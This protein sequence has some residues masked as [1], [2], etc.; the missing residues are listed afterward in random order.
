M[1]KNPTANPTLPYSLKNVA[2]LSNNPRNARTHSKE[3]I[4]KIAK[5]IKKFG[6][7]NPLII[8]ATGGLVAGHGRLAAAKKIKLTEVPC[9]VAE[10]LSPEE[11]RAY[12]LADNRI[13]QD[14]GWNEEILKVELSELS[15][16][17]FDLSFTGFEQ[18]E[19]GQ[20][21]Q[22]TGGSGIPDN[23]KTSG[24]LSEKFLF[25]PFSVLSAR[26]GKWQARKQAWLSI[27]IK[28]EIGRGDN[29]LKFS[30]A[31]NIQ[32]KSGVAY[33]KSKFGKCLETGIGENTGA[34]K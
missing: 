15:S 25:P 28:S 4:D 30:E 10:H 29:L 16:M 24:N 1:S 12:M 21:L 5:S 3:Q 27:G 6:F 17:D 32:Q 2:E 7:I 18:T 20:L 31:C 13:Q 33:E 14:A 26:D 9:L 8:D 11:L 34:M 22:S 23:I 19:I